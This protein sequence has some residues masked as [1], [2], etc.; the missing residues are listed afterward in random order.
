LG[1]PPVQK[2][3]NKIEYHSKEASHQEL[4]SQ[5]FVAWENQAQY[6]SRLSEEGQSAYRNVVVAC[7]KY[8]TSKRE[9]AKHLGHDRPP[10]KKTKKEINVFTLICNEGAVLKDALIA[11]DEIKKVDDVSV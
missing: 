8:I 3:A 7:L 2:S 1:L 9:K 10:L 5:D 4:I 11:I 6:F